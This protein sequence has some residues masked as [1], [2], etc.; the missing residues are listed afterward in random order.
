M[1]AHIDWKAKAGA[2]KFDARPLVGGARVDAEGEE[3]KSVSPRDGSILHSFAAGSAADA[4]RAISSAR[5]TYDQGHWRSLSPLIRKSILLGFAN[6]IEGEKEEL[7]LL[8]TLEMGKPIAQA[9]EDAVGCAHIIRYYAEW[10]DK[11]YGDSAPAMA[12]SI[13][14]NRREPHGVVAAIVPWNY[15]LPNAALKIG[16]ALAAGNSVVLKP[17]EF[18]PSSA[19]RIGEL[20]LASGIP[21]G[22]LNVVPGLGST[23]GAALATHPGVDFVA[24]TGSTATGRELLRLTSQSSLKPLQLECGGKSATL[25]LED[26]GDIDAVADD[27]AQRIF[28]NQG[29]LCVAG[30]RLIVEHGMRAALVEAV[31]ARAKALAIGDP[32]DPDTAFGPLAT[33]RRTEAVL[34]AVEQARSD[35][36]RCVH[37]GT[38]GTARGGGSFFEPTILDGVS[39]DMPAATTDIFGPVLCVMSYRDLDEAITLANA[40]PYGL[41]AVVWTRDLQA[42]ARTIEELRAGRVTVLAAAPHP[43]SAAAPLASEPFGQS[44]IGAEGGRQGY[45]LYTRLKAVEIHH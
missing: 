16:P 27:V 29:Q 4:C 6:A 15:P 7:A 5:Q 38:A 45:E 26:V 17:S 37:G 23:V 31:V 22:A 10:A 8:D 13:Q 20:A 11:A 40:A 33:K 19:I 12:R 41:S 30:T 32:L 2:V 34:K 14:Y 35:G 44:G 25:V 21:A 39:P 36:A 28:T 42:A 9:L 43:L 18:S 24:F 3:I 1:N